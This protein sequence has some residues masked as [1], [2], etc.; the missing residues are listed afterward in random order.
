MIFVIVYCY[1]PAPVNERGKNTLQTATAPPG[2]YI[3]IRHK[4]R[5]RHLA[6]GEG[7]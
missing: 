2:G 4:K 5:T 6:R 3:W 7:Q 1:G